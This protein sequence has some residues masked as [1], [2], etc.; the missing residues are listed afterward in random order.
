[1]AAHYEYRVV[2]HIPEDDE[3]A[4]QEVVSARRHTTTEAAMQE[5]SRPLKRGYPEGTERY[6]EVRSYT[7]W[8]RL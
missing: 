8:E 1:M 4:D 6:I 3:W 2:A 5:M 7:D